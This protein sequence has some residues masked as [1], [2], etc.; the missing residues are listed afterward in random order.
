MP[1]YSNN[2][3]LDID[4]LICN[5]YR[6]KNIEWNEFSIKVNYRNEFISFI[7][8][9]GINLDMKVLKDAKILH[10]FLV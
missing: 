4:R 8:L 1:F 7:P 6:L 2:K 3:N 9:E 5:N 10:N